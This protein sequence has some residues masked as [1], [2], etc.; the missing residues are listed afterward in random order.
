MCVENAVIFQTDVFSSVPC[1]SSICILYK[2]VADCAG[3]L[4]AVRPLDFYSLYM[5]CR[6]LHKDSSWCKKTENTFIEDKA[7]SCFI[8]KVFWEGTSVN[9]IFLGRRSSEVAAQFSMTTFNPLCSNLL[10]TNCFFFSF[11]FLLS[12]LPERLQLWLPD[13]CPW[14]ISAICKNGLF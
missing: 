12:T 11:S 8:E 10:T 14:K 7:I 9:E 2:C 1:A 6:H 3:C 5:H 13:N 4:Y